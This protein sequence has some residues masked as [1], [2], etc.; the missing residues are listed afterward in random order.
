MSYQKTEKIKKWQAHCIAALL[1]EECKQRDDH[2]DEAAN[3]SD[4]CCLRLD[5]LTAALAGKPALIIEHLTLIG[6]LKAVATLF[7]VA[8][9]SKKV[10]GRPILIGGIV[11]ESLIHQIETIQETLYFL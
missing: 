7:K 5:A 4:D 9:T 8:F 10:K 1:A 3:G 6:Y 2:A 11:E